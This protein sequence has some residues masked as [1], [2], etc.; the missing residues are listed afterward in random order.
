MPKLSLLSNK[1]ID[2]I[3][4][5]GHSLAGVDIPYFESIDNLTGKIARWKVYYRR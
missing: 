2:E 1:D 4:V 5:I 3:Y